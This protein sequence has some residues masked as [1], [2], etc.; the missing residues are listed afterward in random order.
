MMLYKWILA[1]KKPSNQL[2]LTPTYWTVI[3]S[4]FVFSLRLGEETLPHNILPNITKDVL[5]SLL[6]VVASS[7]LAVIT[8][9]LSIMVGHFL[10]PQ[11]VQRQEHWIWSWMIKVRER[12]SVVLFALLFMQS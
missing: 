2:W 5:G 4:L 11:I 10:Q 12:L 1:L 8:F 9:S 3:T 7:M 6:N